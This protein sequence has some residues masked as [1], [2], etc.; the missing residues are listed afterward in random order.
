MPWYK[1]E[2]VSVQCR[3]LDECVTLPERTWEGRVRERNSNSLYLPFS[4]KWYVNEQSEEK[5]QKLEDS[6]HS[7][8]NVLQSY[9]YQKQMWKS[10]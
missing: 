6:K 4:S 1:T 2:K 10:E 5:L 9:H 3:F 8:E 7:F